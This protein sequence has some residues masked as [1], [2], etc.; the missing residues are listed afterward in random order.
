MDRESLL[1]REVKTDWM[2][3]LCFHHA[4]VGRCSLRARNTDTFSLLKL[5]LAAAPSV[6]IPH[7]PRQSLVSAR[8]SGATPCYNEPHLALRLAYSR[9]GGK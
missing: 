4:R 7:K 2:K 6:V 1:Y 9:R 8:H 3:K 5:I